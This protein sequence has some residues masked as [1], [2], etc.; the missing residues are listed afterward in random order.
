MLTLGILFVC[1]DQ[2]ED[3]ARIILDFASKVRHPLLG[4]AEKV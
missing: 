3:Q 2:F 4:N 1:K